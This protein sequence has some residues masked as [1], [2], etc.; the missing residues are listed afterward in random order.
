MTNYYLENP[1]LMRDAPEKQHNKN[2]KHSTQRLPS[3]G[4][5]LRSKEIAKAKEEGK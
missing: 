5:N 3:G 1:A 2:S 4:G